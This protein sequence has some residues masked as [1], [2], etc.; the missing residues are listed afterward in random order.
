MP[1]FRRENE[2]IELYKRLADQNRERE[3][4]IRELR[5]RAEREKEELR[6]RL[7]RESG[8]LRDRLERENEELRAALDSQRR[9]LKD[10]IDQNMY[11]GNRRTNELAEKIGKLVGKNSFM[12]NVKSKVKNLFLS[13]SLSVLSR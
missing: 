4:E 13:L 11:D 12:F 10:N 6:G 9:G 8:E 5:E 2:I 1:S 7:E 3:R